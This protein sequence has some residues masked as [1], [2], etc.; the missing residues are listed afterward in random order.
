L[1]VFRGLA[2][3]A[4]A[5]LMA[6]SIMTAGVSSAAVST[7]PPFAQC[8]AVGA[9]PSCQI[10]VVVNTD[11]T[12]TVLGDPSVGPYDGGDDT[13]VGVLNNS[14]APAQA[15]TVNG[16]GTGLAG[17]DGDGLCT[18]GIAGCPFGPT[19]YEGPGTTIKTDPSLPDSAEID[20]AGAGLAS[21]QSAYFSLEGALT[22]AALTARQGPLIPT[23]KL[24]TAVQSYP[25]D[26][27][28]GPAYVRL[29]ITA[30]NGDGTPASN[31][32]VKLSN[33][34]PTAR[35][36]HTNAL[37]V[38]RL[39]E[40]VNVTAANAGSPVNITAT[41]TAT[42]G[43]TATAT[44]ELFEAEP[45]VVCTFDGRPGRDISV[46]KAMLDERLSFILDL[47]EYFGPQFSKVH[48][49]AVGYIITVPGS[50]SFYAQ[51]IEITRRG[52]GEFSGIGYSYDQILKP[53]ASAYEGAQTGCGSPPA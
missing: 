4:A 11:R 10:L 49:N 52:R 40:S 7:T 45:H 26:P 18:F 8:P 12:V 15:I 47:V 24:T 33:A 1:R 3:I 13:L 6:L 28:P 44:Q 19:G 51:S 50:R 2:T 42:T 37:G 34:L 35:P 20:F 48:T 5:A 32:T 31:A 29:K 46:L 36:L 30:K 14:R 16:P 41:V 17:L 43:A 23:V 53:P 27:D 21:G 22:S 38:L 25:I 39:L 9:S